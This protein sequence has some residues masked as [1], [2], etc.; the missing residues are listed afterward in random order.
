MQ[1]FCKFFSSSHEGQDVENRKPHLQA[2]LLKTKQ[3]RLFL[4]SGELVK[5]RMTTSCCA[6]GGWG[7]EA[8]SNPA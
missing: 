2:I 4:L 7:N 1:V 5:G 3:S 8:Q 6:Y